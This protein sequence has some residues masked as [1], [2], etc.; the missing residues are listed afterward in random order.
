MRGIHR[1]GVVAGA[2][3]LAIAPLAALAQ[4]PGRTYRIAVWSSARALNEI[5]E[6]GEIQ[7]RTFF[8]ELRR[9]GFVPGRNLVVESYANNG[10]SEQYGPTAQKIAASSPDLILVASPIP[11]ATLLRNITTSIP[12]VIPGVT[13][14]IAFGLVQSLARP[15]GSITGFTLDG[16]VE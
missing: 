8:A 16:G 14:P 11:A 2:L 7:F 13:D 12:L 1:R 6:D 5:G 15:G 9:L 10:V 3:A 4:A